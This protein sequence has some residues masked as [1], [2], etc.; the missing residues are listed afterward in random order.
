MR[1]PRCPTYRRAQRQPG[2]PLSPVRCP[3]ARDG[4]RLRSTR[5]KRTRC[6]GRLPP[7][8]VRGSSPVRRWARRSSRAL[9]KR[10]ATGFGHVALPERRV[11]TSGPA[12]RSGFVRL[13]VTDS[14]VTGTERGNPQPGRQRGIARHALGHDGR[15]RSKLRLTPRDRPVVDGPSH[16]SRPGRRS[17]LGRSAPGALCFSPSTPPPTPSGCPESHHAIWASWVAESE[18]RRDSTLPAKPERD[19]R[20]SRFSA[21]HADWRP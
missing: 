13:G 14:F 17:G 21:C 5:R 7:I 2:P 4:E 10:A 3:R 20:S 1:P 12:S 9:G 15:C 19:R 11:L 18:R 6:T 8:L 16:W